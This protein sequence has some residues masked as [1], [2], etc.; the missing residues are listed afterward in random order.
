MNDIAHHDFAESLQASHDATD[1]PIWRYIYRQ[2]FPSFLAMID[3]R[4]DGEHQRAGIDRSVI[5][6][7]SKQILIDEKVRFRNRITGKVYSDIALEYISNDRTKAPG[8]VC[9]PLRADFIAYAIAPLGR[10]YLLPV[11][12]MQLAWERNHVKW[13]AEYRSISAQNMGYK[14]LS[15]PLP[16]DVLFPAIG[17]ALRVKFSP[18]D[19]HETA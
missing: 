11:L 19:I 17:G 1:L 7:N 18:V 14:T 2:A 9:K 8:W 5:L 12:Q 3:H 13:L 10:C 4:E 16:P 15:L 6:K